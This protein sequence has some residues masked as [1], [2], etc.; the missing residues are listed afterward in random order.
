M[1]SFEE[2]LLDDLEWDVLENTVPE[3]AEN[4]A[5]I[6]VKNANNELLLI[7]RHP[8]QRHALQW[9]CPG[10][11]FLPHEEPIEAAQRQLFEESGLRSTK[12]ELV[13]LGETEQAGYHIYSYLYHIT[14]PN[15]ILHLLPNEAV[16]ARYIDVE[17]VDH[18]EEEIIP[19]VWSRFLMYGDK[20]KSM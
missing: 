13:Y 3:N 9:E 11:P 8:S 7:Q 19:T 10:G 1:M 16:E 14:D 15:V 6:W 2:A 17:I 12:E 18:I 4:I 20:I 5:E